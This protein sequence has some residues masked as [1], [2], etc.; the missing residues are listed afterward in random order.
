MDHILSLATLKYLGM[1]HVSPHLYSSLDLY[2][3]RE[4]GVLSN[5]VQGM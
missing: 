2:K 5:T 4:A 1:C 3:C